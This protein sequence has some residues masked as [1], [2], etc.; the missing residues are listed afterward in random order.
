M[1][2][3]TGDEPTVRAAVSP[4]AEK[5][6]SAP[7]T[8]AAP[9]RPRGSGRGRRRLLLAGAAALVVAVGIALAVVLPREDTP[10]GRDDEPAAGADPA[11]YRVVEPGT[12]GE[13]TVQLGSDAIE[14]AG[15]YR[16]LD[17]GFVADAGFTGLAL[18]PQPANVEQRVVD[19]TADIGISSA[20][21]AAVAVDR[22][23]PL[24]V[25]ATTLTSTPL[26]VLSLADGA[27]VRE[28]ADLVGLRVGVQDSNLPMFDRLLE[29]NGVDPA[30]LEI[31]SVDLDP[32]VLADGDVDA[33]VGFTTDQVPTLTAEGYDVAVVEFAD[34]GVAFPSLAIVVRDDYLAAQRDAV[35]A[36]LVAVVR[37]WRVAL[38]RPV[39]ETVALVR[40]ES[41]QTGKGAGSGDDAA[42]DA[43]ALQA[44]L[45]RVE[46]DGTLQEALLL[47]SEEQQEQVVAAAA[48]LGYDVAADELF[49][50][51]LLQ[52]VYARY[53]ELR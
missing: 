38:E 25:V 11:A 20:V 19:G 41:G 42:R 50:L 13:V 8:P 31:V 51:S 52:D 21:A 33:V 15:E 35:E 34:A 10:E 30:Q 37:G 6:P 29:V 32:A 44:V 39:D 45:D 23:D 26:A 40:G 18:L 22:G 49:D 53:P 43:L 5:T 47:T 7:A 24:T 9:G 48:V 12:Y 27:D 16:A 17:E 1:S 28:V 46:P 2:G 36:F 14:Y 4:T 3:E